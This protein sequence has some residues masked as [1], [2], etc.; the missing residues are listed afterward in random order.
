MSDLRLKYLVKTSTKTKLFIKYLR[1]KTGVFNSKGVQ[2]AELQFSN[3][4]CL[5]I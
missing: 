4:A 3:S 1:R 5:Y 2:K